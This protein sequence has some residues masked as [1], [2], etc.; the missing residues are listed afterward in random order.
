MA[1]L[2]PGAVVI[3]VLSCLSG[4][5]EHESNTCL[6]QILCHIENFWFMSSFT[7]IAF[8]FVSV[9]VG[10]LIHGLNWT[11]LAYL[12]NRDNSKEPK[13]VRDTNYHKWKLFKQLLLSPFIMIYEII[14]LIIKTKNIGQLTM[15][16]NIGNIKSEY[17]EQFQ[18]LQDFYL[19]FS[20]FYAHMGYAF[21][22]TLFAA[23]VY[24]LRKPSL[25]LLYSI[26]CFYLLTGVFFLLGRIQLGTLFKSENVL[27]EKSS[28]S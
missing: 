13:P 22:T 8:L 24:L 28:S 16:E 3:I 7:I 15:D 23:L 10:M 21:L 17:M 1:Q 14:I 6:K 4:N 11:I 19:S 18:F 26:I 20:Q 25:G 12:E 9:A 5:F 27:R 2:L